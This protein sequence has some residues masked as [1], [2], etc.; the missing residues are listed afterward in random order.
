MRNIDRILLSGLLMVLFWTTGAAGQAEQAH[1]KFSIGAGIGV[2]Q[3]MGDWTDHRY[4]PGVDQFSRGFLGE[5]II[6]YQFGTWGAAAAFFSGSS[7]G[8]GDWED[9]AQSMGD[10]VTANAHMYHYG[11]L[12]RPYLLYR[13]AHIVKLDFG[14]G[15]FQAKGNE[16]FL[17]FSYDYTFLQDKASLIT[18]IEYSRFFNRNLAIS[19]RVGFLFADGGVNFADGFTQNVMGLPVTV[20]I[21]FYPDI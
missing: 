16:S 18:G 21:R 13:P 2:F 10:D 14:I 19:V 15:V 12:F 4:A 5:G 11:V 3:P 17:Y 20:G 9:Y 1:G 8:V 6:E 7:L